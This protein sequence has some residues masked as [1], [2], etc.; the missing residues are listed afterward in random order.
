MGKPKNKKKWGCLIPVII[1]C[2][3]SV[4]FAYTLLNG[5]NLDSKQ[6]GVVMSATSMSKE[7]A[8][9]AISI[10]SELGIDSIDKLEHDKS[11][12]NMNID[13]E[14]GY[15]LESSGINNIILYIAK[16]NVINMV[17]WADNS[18]YENG[19]VV[20]KITDYTLTNEEISNLE[21]KCE[22]LVKSALK[23]PST[24]KFPN[25]LKWKFSKNKERIIVQ[26]YVDSENSFGA[27][28]R[29]DF[30]VIFTQDSSNISSF[31]FDGKEYIK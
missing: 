25:I 4:V 11:L 7:E 13:G 2:I 21:I 5:D 8:V 9:K 27:L 12:D 10:L 14:K 15:R 29:G 6:E 23:S 26:S 22:D 18:L 28:V 24:A 17:R 31:I 20:S 19:K 16:N 30:Q 3:L 1:F